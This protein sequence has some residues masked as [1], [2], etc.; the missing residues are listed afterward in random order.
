MTLK[1]YAKFEEEL[2]CRFKITIRNLT[3]FY[4]KTQKSRKTCTLM[5]YLSPK[6]IMFELKKYRGMIFNDT[7]E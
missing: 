3:N 6:Y 4:S 5:A 2:T 7:E 1:N